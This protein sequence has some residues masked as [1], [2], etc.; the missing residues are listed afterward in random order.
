[1]VSCWEKTKSL[2]LPTEPKWTQW[3]NCGSI[4]TVSGL[5]R[6]KNISAAVCSR[7]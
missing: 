2:L 6:G 1:M 4:C 5:F 7:L 3:R